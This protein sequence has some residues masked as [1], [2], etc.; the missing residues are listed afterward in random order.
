MSAGSAATSDST[1]MA[2]ELEQFRV[3]LI[4]YCYRML[5]SPFE[6]EDAVQE[7]LLHAWRRFDRYDEKRASL[8][9]WLYAIA[10]NVCIDMLRSTQRRARAMDLGPPSQVGPDLGTP[11]PER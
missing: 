7:T 3:E 9:S 6:A 5:G 4:G 2:L 8:R 10:T 1:A 11:L